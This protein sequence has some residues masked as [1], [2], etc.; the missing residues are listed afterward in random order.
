MR[1]LQIVA[2]FSTAGSVSTRARGGGHSKFIH[3]CCIIIIT[4]V[5]FC[6]AGSVSEDFSSARGGGH[7]KFI[8][9]CCIIIITCVFFY[10]R[11]S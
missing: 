5:F 8:H 7:S 4:C 3:L 6:T 1:T 10:S 2:C 9:L 11:I